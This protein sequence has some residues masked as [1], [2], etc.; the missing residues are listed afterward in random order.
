MV[1]LVM[2]VLKLLKNLF[3]SSHHSLHALLANINEVAFEI[4]LR[5]ASDA[6]ESS[7]PDPA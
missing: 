7:L 2:F 4:G 5:A 6:D 1:A 3:R